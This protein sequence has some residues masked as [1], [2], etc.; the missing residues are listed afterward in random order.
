M[1]QIL[2]LTA[3]AL[4]EARKSSGSSFIQTMAL[5]LVQRVQPLDKAQQ[6][7]EAGGS[8]SSISVKDQ[9]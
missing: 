6:H 1:L 3:C 2:V 7:T 9:W 5:G 4:V 8:T